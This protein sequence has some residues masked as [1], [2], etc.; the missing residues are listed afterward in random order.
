MN[1]G[2]ELDALVAEKV[3]GLVLTCPVDPRFDHSVGTNR[4]G[5]SAKRNFCRWPDG[6]ET[7]I[8]FYSTDIAA[9]WQ[10]FNKFTSRYIWYDDATSVWHCH[11]DSRRCVMDDCRW[12]AVSEDEDG[13]EAI[14]LAALQA[15]GGER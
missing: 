9:A 11:F 6:K 15:V 4:D 3:M 10:V 7:W 5:S 8:P 12:H 1:A 14:C 2:R 13:C